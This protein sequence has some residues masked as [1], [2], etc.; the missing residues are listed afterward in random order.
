MGTFR[1][2]W[3]GV[4]TIGLAACNDPLFVANLNQPDR[5]RVFSNP[6]DLEQFVSALYANVHAG[7]LG[8]GTVL[9]GGSNDALQPQ[10][11]VMGLENVSALAN[12]AMGPR[13]AVPRNP[14]TNARGSQGN[15]GN[16]RDWVVEHRAARMAALAIATLKTF[17]LGSAARDGRARAFSRFA[18]GVALGNLALAYDSASILTENDNPQADAQV[19]VPLSGYKVVMAAA[20]QYLDS[21]IAL[22]QADTA[23]TDGFP[24]PSTWINGVSNLDVPN[25]VRLVRSYKA[26]FRASVARTPAERATQDWNAI[27]A[28]ATNGITTDLRITMN[29][30][31]AGGWDMAW[32]IQHFA[33]G[34]ANWHQMSQF[35]LGMA[36]TSGGYTP[37][38]AGTMPTCGRCA[39]LVVTPDRRF[40]QGTTRGTA[41]TQAGTQVGNSPGP[42]GTGQNSP[43]PFDSTP[44]FRNR[45]PGE[46]QPGDAIGI[47]Q[48]E[49]YRSRVFRNAN[50]TGVYPVMTA[51]EIR[52]YAA[53]AQLRVGTV[54]AA[55]ALIDVSR[56]GKGKL[57]SLV[58]AAITDT[59]MR[60]PGVNGVQGSNS[61]VPRIPD[62]AANFKATQCG[63]IW[64][65]LKW[66]Y[67]METAYT[68]Y[69][70]WFFAGR[71]WGDLPEGTALDWPVP[72][73]E[74][75]SRAETFYGTGGVGG[76]DAANRGNYGL[77]GGGVY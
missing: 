73:Q 38:L 6:T 60:V 36:D 7:T 13:G 47:S 27:L 61:C 31:P 59:V 1:F 25:F 56:T 12:F 72:Y 52:L 20:L 53:E 2:A 3:Y 24:L 57:S 4:L 26:R 33:T 46:D 28:D 18:Q 9:G 37:W 54:A 44:Y 19:V 34:A 51:A 17:T 21:A 23:K 68:G 40:P 66:E 35:W 69:G 62:P 5:G 45:P 14:I 58:T 48:Y 76:R 63:N 64:D 49:F 10:L 16:Y 42:G 39:F 8:Q 71:G 50:R 77:F 67:R 32:V 43:I 30:P 22:A 15:V 70:M 65:A 11:Q 75:D 55:A 41:V 29:P 74:M